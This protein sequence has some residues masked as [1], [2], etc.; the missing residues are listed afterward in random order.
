MSK[1]GRIARRMPLLGERLLIRDAERRQANERLLAL[2]AEVQDLTRHA[3]ELETELAQRRS[4]EAVADRLVAALADVRVEQTRQVGL[5][6]SNVAGMATRLEDGIRSLRTLGPQMGRDP[7]LRER[8][9]DLLESALTGS[10]WGDP[11]MD[12]WSGQSYELA[13]RSVG[14]DW[15]SL[16]ATMIGTAR[17]CNIRTL[18]QRILTER[19]PGDLIETGAWRGGACIYMRGILA[20]FGDANRRVFVADSFKG[21]PKPDSERYPNDEGDLHHTFQA[22]AVSRVEVENNFRRFGLWDDRVI[23]LEGWFKDTLPVAPIDQLALLRLDGDM[24]ESTAQA[25]EALY[26][27]VSPGGFVIVDDYN[28]GPCARAVDD[29]RSS[30]GITAAIQEIDGAGIWW[31]VE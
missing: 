31:T 25:L 22:L 16:A 3:A 10:I 14:G 29:Y 19:I 23:V 20:A 26:T 2:T 5:V 30:H 11:A 12:P 13:M 7:V 15:P 21:L 6:A 1:L 18:V 27:K 17:I 4:C 24:Y 8:Y 9:L 28:L